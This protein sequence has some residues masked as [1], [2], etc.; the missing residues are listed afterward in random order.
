MA[1]VII[2]ILL[3]YLAAALVAKG[4]M[5]QDVSD[6]FGSDPDIAGLVEIAIGGASVFVAEGWYFLAKKFGLKT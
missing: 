6:L 5:S 4:L 3:R 1:G 2:R